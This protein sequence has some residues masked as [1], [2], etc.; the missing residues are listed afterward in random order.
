VNNGRRTSFNLGENFVNNSVRV[1]IDGIVAIVVGRNMRTFDSYSEQ[2]ICGV[3]YSFIAR[4]LVH[5]Q[6]RQI[7]RPFVIII[8]HNAL[9]ILQTLFIIIRTG[10]EE[11]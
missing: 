3:Q 7:N 2:E 4:K 10:C 1:L 6:N 9:V 11:Q 5:C 8:Y